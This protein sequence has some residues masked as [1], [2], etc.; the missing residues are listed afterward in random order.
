VLNS[1]RRARRVELTLVSP[2]GTKIALVINARDL[3]DACPTLS[4]AAPTRFV[5]GTIS[6][7][8]RTART[9]FNQNVGNLIVN[10]SAVTS[11]DDLFPSRCRHGSNKF[12]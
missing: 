12:V 8:R 9:S 1:S 4:S 10:G 6:V 3:H 11:G 5:G 7:G 2:Y